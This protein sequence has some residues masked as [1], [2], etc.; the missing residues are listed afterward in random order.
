MTTSIADDQLTEAAEILRSGGLV[1]FPTETVYGL[2]GDATN[3][4]AVA[5]IFAA[6]Q[7]P[8]LDPVIVHLSDPEQLATVTTAVPPT[9]ATLAEAFW[10]G[11]LTLVLPRADTIPSIVSSGLPTVAVRVPAHASARRLITLAGCPIAAPSANRFGG[12]SPTTAA[13]V[14][15]QLGDRIERILDGGPCRIGVESTVLDVSGPLP[16][17]LRPGGLTREELE[18]AIGPITVATEHLPTGEAAP[19]PGMLARHYSPDTPVTVTD[20]IDSLPAGRL[21]LLTLHRPAPNHDWAHIE[22]LSETGD[23]VEAA[24]GFF[25]ALH[26]LDDAGLDRIIALPFPNS[27][28]G[29]ALNNRLDRAAGT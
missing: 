3:A 18:A 14:V 22:V 11:P 20:T 29:L 25:A 10:P 1:A 15:S 17:M 16:V 26:R 27:G 6:K 8:R 28:L 2:G 12:I 13:H 21:G 23:L 7:R 9:A 5:K 4:R 19:A 24:A